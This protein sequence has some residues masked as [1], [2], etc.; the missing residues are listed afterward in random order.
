MKNI[1]IVGGG[2]S[3]WLT[4]LVVNKFW[5][6]TIVTL[7]ESE[8]IGIL[9]A[10]EGGTPNFGKMISLLGI[11]ENEFFYE[12]GA[13]IKSGLHL[14]NWLSDDAE[15]EHYFCGENI[16]LLKHKYA[17]HFDAQKVAK[18][19]KKISLER[20]VIH[21]NSEVN[22]LKIVNDNVTEISLISGQIINNIHTVFDCSGFARLTTERFSKEEWID[23]SKYLL[24][25]KSFGFFLP[26]E[27]NIKITDKIKTDVIALSCGWL[28]KIELQHRIGCGY[29]FSDKHITVED[30]KREVENYLNREITIQKVFDY[31]PGRFKRSWIGNRIA[32]GLSYG[33]LEPLEATGLMSTIMQLKRLID[34][35]F[36]ID[37]RT[38]FNKW[39][40]EIYEQNM[41]F[42]RYHYLNER[43]DTDFWIDS[44]NAPIPDKLKKILDDDK[45]LIPRTNE[46]LLKEL[47]LKETSENE[48]TFMV[49]NYHIIYKKNKKIPHKSIV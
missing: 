35:D 34:V 25:N 39:C 1:V 32:V 28:W 36:D 5:K 43:F 49:S 21:V 24:L 37:Y 45:M 48:L 42:V 20:G 41:I 2:A 18:Y 3:G 6:N 15:I 23:Y 7:I 26:Q 4:A 11:N 22:D 30:A 19:F 29:S 47:D 31:K 14:K 44:Y 38:R 17:Y 13:T 33:F 46:E 9:G 12:T 10:G 40:E 8:K 27:K 16:P